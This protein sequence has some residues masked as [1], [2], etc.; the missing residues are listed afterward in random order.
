MSFCAIGAK[1]NDN[2]LQIPHSTASDLTL[3]LRYL[4]N[5][6]ALIKAKLEAE[7]ALVREQTSHMELKHQVKHLNTL[8]DDLQSR[9]ETLQTEK[10]NLQNNKSA[11]GKAD[12]LF[13]F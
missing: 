1:A 6:S 13:S 5:H 7:A 9:I 10:T 12:L 2:Y 3:E 8:T 11:I 4:R